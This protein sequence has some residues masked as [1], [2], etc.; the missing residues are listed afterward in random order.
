M[1]HYKRLIR[2][3]NPAILLDLKIYRELDW[4]FEFHFVICQ[5][6]WNIGAIISNDIGAMPFTMKLAQ[7]ID[8]MLKE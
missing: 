3:K 1:D 8:N 5:I 2:I 6:K 4:S 7:K